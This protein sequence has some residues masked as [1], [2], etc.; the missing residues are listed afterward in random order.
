VFDS[1]EN[2]TYFGSWD[3]PLRIAMTRIVLTGIALSTAICRAQQPCEN[4]TKLSL[5]KISI[6]AAVRIA[7][8]SFNLPGG[9]S[10][11]APA[12]VRCI[13]PA[14]RSTESRMES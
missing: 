6:T 10:G 9:R 5:A 1:L 4:L 7:A 8:G 14:T 2:E 12:N 3:V 13:K 11:A